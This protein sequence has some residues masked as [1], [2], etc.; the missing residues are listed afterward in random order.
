M[1]RHISNARPAGEPPLY[2]LVL[3]GGRSV[4]MGRDKGSL[5]YHGRPQA[6][7]MLDLV[8]RHC[9][10]AF[11]SVRDEQASAQPYA[12]LPLVIDE[13]RIEGPAAGLLAA[14]R[15]RPDVAWLVVGADMALLD[16]ATLA[17]LARSRDATRTATAYRHPDGTAEPL[18]A[19]WEPAARALLEPQGRP[20]ISL[21]RALEEGPTRFVAAADPTRLRSVNTAADD[22]A[23]RALIGGS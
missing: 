3:A 9:E 1:P 15:H 21:R 19:I 12:G 16:D 18:C 7:W 22:R 17:E 6:L 23:I 13:G 2:G 8:S 5:D 4:R 14:F 20:S 11:V 10:H